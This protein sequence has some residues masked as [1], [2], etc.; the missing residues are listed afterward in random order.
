LG[1]SKARRLLQLAGGKIWIASAI[2]EGTS[3]FVHLPPV[4]ESAESNKAGEAKP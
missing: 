3:V 4:E 2:D 1:L